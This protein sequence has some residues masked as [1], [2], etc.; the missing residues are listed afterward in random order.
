MLYFKLTS[1]GAGIFLIFFAL[2]AFLSPQAW[3]DFQVRK[4]WRE[5]N[6]LVIAFLFLIH[7]VLAL[8]GWFL[9]FKVYHHPYAFLASGFLTV[10]AIKLGAALALYKVFRPAVVMLLTTEATFRYLFMAGALLLGG[11]MFYLGWIIR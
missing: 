10:A 11:G 8:I 5:G 1:F 2:W 4:I 6:P 7:F 3:T 9:S